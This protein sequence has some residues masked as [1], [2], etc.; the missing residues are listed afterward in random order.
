LQNFAKAFFYGSSL[1]SEWYAARF[2]KAGMTTSML[3]T[4][5]PEETF[6]LCTA[7]EVKSKLQFYI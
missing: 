5:K 6:L 1:F 7:K 2:R 3:S 4:G